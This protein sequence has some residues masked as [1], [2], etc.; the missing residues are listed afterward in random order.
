ME[1][2]DGTPADPDT[3]QWRYVPGYGTWCDT[4]VLRDPRRR[5]QLTDMIFFS[6]VTVITDPSDSRFDLESFLKAKLG[7]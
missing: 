3:R 7:E 1:E 6:S 4:G 2:E 5:R